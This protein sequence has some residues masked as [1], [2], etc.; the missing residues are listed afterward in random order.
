MK[1]PSL[2]ALIKPG[3]STFILLLITYLAIWGGHLLWW[4]YFSDASSTLLI[5]S[6]WSPVYHVLA[7]L[8]LVAINSVLLRRFV[9][10]FSIIRIKS[11]LPV[12]LFL[13]FTATWPEL[14]MD[15]YAHLFLTAFLLSLEFF[16][17]MFRNRTAVEHSFLGS[18]IISLLSLAEPLYLFIIPVVWIGFVI[19]KSFSLRTW[20]AS[21]TGL[22]IP[23]IFFNAY[24]WSKGIFTEVAPELV[25]L[26]QPTL[27]FPVHNPQFLVFIGL[28]SGS[29]I[30]LLIGLFRKILD[31][32]IQTRKY[33]YVL[34]L[35][36]MAIILFLILHQQNAA[37]FLP[38]LA[39][40]LAILMA[41]PLSLL[42]PAVYPIL[43]YCIIALHL[44]LLISQ[45]LFI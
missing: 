26:L 43:F 23:W 4:P 45:Y 39:F 18:L 3:L 30:I 29:V 34:F 35:L 33:I 9:L 2:H 19:L 40:F 37:R 44:F 15:L 25:L 32:S 8:F 5:N 28:I 7:L 1:T 16:F 31:D 13:V 10:H 24:F 14:R 17:G 11:F 38:L 41:H 12:F 27:Y 21:L 42:K 22:A 6:G 20:L 36:M